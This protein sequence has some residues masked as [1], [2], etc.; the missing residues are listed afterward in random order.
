MPLIPSLRVAPFVEIHPRCFDYVYAI[1]MPWPACVADEWW[2]WS[3]LDKIARCVN[4][5]YSDSDNDRSDIQH[6]F[7]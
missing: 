7:F 1:A 6:F 2:G 3:A 4:N 5:G